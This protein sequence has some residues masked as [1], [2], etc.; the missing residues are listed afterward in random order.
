[1][2]RK[3]PKITPHH[4]D[5]EVVQKA[6]E[7]FAGVKMTPDAAVAMFYKLTALR[8]DGLRAGKPLNAESLAAFNEPRES[9]AIYTIVDEMMADLWEVSQT[10]GQSF[11]AG[12]IETKAATPTGLD[13]KNPES[14]LA[15]KAETVFAQMGMSPEEAITTF[16]ERTAL[17]DDCLLC[18]AYGKI[19]NE[20]TQ[21]AMREPV[22]DMVTYSSVDEMMADLWPDA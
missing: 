3:T 12:G 8:S 22:E 14:E 7:I 2:V 16:Y 6:E 1:M 10:A 4:H 15:Q 21:A 17:H 5:P 18:L 11:T 19:P 13:P 9:I 20:E